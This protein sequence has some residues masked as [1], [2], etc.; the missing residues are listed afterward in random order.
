M[1]E[2]RL[3]NEKDKKMEEQEKIIQEQEMKMEQKDKAIRKFQ[4]LFEIY[5]IRRRNRERS[6]KRLNWHCT[7]KKWYEE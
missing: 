2:Q 4:E 1:Q 6:F 5:F 7:S 3:I